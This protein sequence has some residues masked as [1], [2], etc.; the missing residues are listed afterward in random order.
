MSE[1][2]EPSL[3]VPPP[4]PPAPPMLSSEEQ[5]VFKGSGSEYFRIWIVNLL[6]SI[7]TL[8]IYSAWAKVRRLQY[9]YGNTELAGS[10]FRYEGNPLAILK[11]RL[12]ALVLLMAYHFSAQYS[13]TAFL[14]VILALALIAPWLLR[15]S[16]RFRL[17]NSSYRGMRFSFTGSNA[18]AYKTFLLYGPL[19]IFTLYLAAPLFHQRLKRYQH[20]N[21]SFGKT[22]F[23]FNASVG[24]FYGA[25]AL[26]ALLMVGLLVGFFMS[27]APIF[28]TLAAK[29]GDHHMSPADARAIGGT[30]MF[31]I[32]IFYAGILFI[33]PLWL[34]RIQN[35]VWN[36]T[37]LGLHQFRS[38]MRVGKLFFIVVTNLIGI[39]LTVGFF[40]PWAAVRMARYRAE[41]TSL[42]VNGGLDD[43]I[44]DQGQE[45]GAAGQETAEFF[46]IDIGL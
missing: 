4:V 23:G 43:F 8:G 37:T 30:M 31:S 32:L 13:V 35:L 1:R 11:G 18:G 10:S 3:A 15:N 38:S 9:F 36:N 14:V 42:V 24:Q 21:A 17:H 27:L 25:Y 41:S 16:F 46:D 2:I 28:S 29:G 22:P 40:A 45:I 33:G 19:A 39:V 5:F 6:L 26:V 12:I 34:T 7:V 20:G 44:A